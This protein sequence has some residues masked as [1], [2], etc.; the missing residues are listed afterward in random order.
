MEEW[1]REIDRQ[2]ESVP[3]ILYDLPH[4]NDQEAQIQWLSKLFH[5]RW[6]VY[7]KSGR[8][9]DEIEVFNKLSHIFV[10]IDLGH[11]GSDRIFLDDVEY[12]MV[13]H[14]YINPNHLQIPDQRCFNR[15][16]DASENRL[17]VYT[18]D[19]IPSCKDIYELLKNSFCM[20]C[21]YENE[22]KNHRVGLIH[23]SAYAKTWFYSALQFLPPPFAACLQDHG[24]DGDR[25]GGSFFSSWFENNLSSNIHFILSQPEQMYW[26][27]F[28]RFSGIAKGRGGVHRVKRAIFY[29]KT[30]IIPQESTDT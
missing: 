17:K 6:T 23:V 29:N 22:T 19:N 21:V 2:T 26:K 16:E 24:F 5:E 18:K 8:D 20:I 28:G 4:R 7:P 1:Y 25:E 13:G 12:K 9:F 11:M 3:S 14:Y 27:N 30:H 10:R 15:S